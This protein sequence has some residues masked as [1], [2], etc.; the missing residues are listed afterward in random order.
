MHF[1]HAAGG[2]GC[3]ADPLHTAVATDQGEESPMMQPYNGM[4]ADHLTTVIWQKSR[5]SNP[6]GNCVEM[7]PLPRGGGVAVRN[8][9]DPNG[10]ALVYTADE[11]VA[12]IRGAKAGDFDNLIQ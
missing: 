5:L 11:I 12:F 6:S 9:R 8:S 2:G 10:P 4:P 7:A 1:I 3:L